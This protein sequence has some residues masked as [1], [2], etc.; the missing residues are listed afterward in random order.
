MTRAERFRL[1]AEECE[2]NGT[3]AK[4]DRAKHLLANAAKQWRDL[5]AY[6][7]RWDAETAFFEDLE[8]RYLHDNHVRRIALEA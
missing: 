8:A 4:D 1:K 7:E 6:A 3:K 2:Q 5:A